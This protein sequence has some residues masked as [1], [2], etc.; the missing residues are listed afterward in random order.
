MIRRILLAF[1][2]VAAFWWI[3]PQAI[4]LLAAI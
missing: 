4:V 1:A 2:T 3:A